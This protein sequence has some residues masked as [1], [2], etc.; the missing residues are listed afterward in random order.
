MTVSTCPE[1]RAFCSWHSIIL[2]YTR[3]YTRTAAVSLSVLYCVVATPP[4]R[5]EVKYAD[6]PNSYTFQPLAFDFETLGPLI[7]SSTTVLSF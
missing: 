7:N 6:L 1:G 3:V 2:G 5:I 4:G